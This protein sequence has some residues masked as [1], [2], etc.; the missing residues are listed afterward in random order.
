M[1]IQLILC[2][3]QI[4]NENLAQGTLLNAKWEENLKKRGYMDTYS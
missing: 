1:H 4:T 2:V 3:K